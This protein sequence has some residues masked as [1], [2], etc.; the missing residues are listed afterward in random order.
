MA[1]TILTFLIIFSFLVAGIGYIV[2]LFQDNNTSF[3]LPFQNTPTPTPAPITSLTLIPETAS[4]LPQQT[5]TVDV[6]FDSSNNTSYKPKIIQMEIGYDPMAL[7]N[8]AIA[9]GDFFPDPSVALNII[10]FKTGRISYALQT[11]KVNQKTKGIV[12]RLS[13][14]PNPTFSGIQTALSFLG[15]TMIRGMANENILT[16]TYGTQ[17]Q[18]ATPSATPKF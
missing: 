17:L 1:K 3:S 14:I 7:E 9:P 5:N 4:V 12:A 10:D 8:V 13:F 16:A 6:V 11:A 15:K 2:I 18:F